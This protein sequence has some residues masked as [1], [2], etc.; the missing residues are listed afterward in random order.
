MRL[1]LVIFTVLGAAAAPPAN[2]QEH[3]YFVTYD[4]YLEEPGNLEVAVAAT[5]GF[6]KNNRRGY[7]APWLEL[8]YGVTGWWTTELYFEGVA[9]RG[10]GRAFT[11]IRFENRFRPLRGEHRVNPVLYVEYEA[12]SEASRMQKEIVGAGVLPDEPLAE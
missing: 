10:N 12:V 4:H 11:G 9:I 7:T 5:T 3:P 6:P 2:A 1:S 8:E